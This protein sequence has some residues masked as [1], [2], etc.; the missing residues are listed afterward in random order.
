MTYERY[1]ES[2]LHPQKYRRQS[3]INVYV[4]QCNSRLRLDNQTGLSIWILEKMGG[5]GGAVRLKGE[6]RITG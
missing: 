1:L 3:T 2:L 4:N 5:E 6:A